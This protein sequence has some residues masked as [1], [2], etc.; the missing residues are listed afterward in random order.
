MISYQPS[1]TPAPAPHASS[2]HAA[3]VSRMADDMREMAF[4]GQNVSHETLVQHGWT[5]PVIKR[6]SPE[7][8]A[9]ARR[10]ST[11]RIG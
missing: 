11:R 9:R 7:A 4:A 2:C 1:P 6:L 5:L 8:T 3:L 10:Q